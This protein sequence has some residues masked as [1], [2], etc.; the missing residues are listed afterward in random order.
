MRIAQV[1]DLVSCYT[2]MSRVKKVCGG[3]LTLR[4]YDAQVGRI[5]GISESVKYDDVT[6]YAAPCAHCLSGE[7]TV[8]LYLE[9][10]LFNKAV[11]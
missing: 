2:T 4:N 7:G 6:G 5:N 10:Y 1:L 8:L 3:W 11:S 9:I